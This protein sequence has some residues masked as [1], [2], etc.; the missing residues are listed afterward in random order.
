[1]ARLPQ[2]A[3]GPSEPEAV[4]KSVVAWREGGLVFDGLPLVDILKAIER[5]YGVQVASNA[6]S[7]SGILTLFLESKPPIE[8]VL[9]LI[10]ASMSCQIESDAD[11]FRISLPEGRNLQGDSK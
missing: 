9:D 7:E 4:D 5:Q 6:D 11:G 1:M 2:G 10:C 3:S 8:T